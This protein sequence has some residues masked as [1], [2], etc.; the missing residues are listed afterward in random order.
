[1]GRNEGCMNLCPSEACSS[2]SSTRLCFLPS[3]ILISSTCW[4]ECIHFNSH[5]QIVLEILTQLA[6]IMPVKTQA[7][8][9]EDSQR[10][11]RVHKKSRKGCRNCKLR[12]VKVKCS[13]M[14][15]GLGLLTDNM[16]FL[17]VMRQD[18]IAWSVKTMD[19]H[20]I[21]TPK[22]QIWNWS[23]PKLLRPWNR[24]LSLVNHHGPSILHHLH[25]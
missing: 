16:I 2:P 6:N 5:D 9:K 3:Y 22:Y 4:Y 20:V 7:D 24:R 8:A 23:I 10:K 17:S 1:M 18:R 25:R 15:L 19:M 11:R 13:P 12:R 14:G 21:M